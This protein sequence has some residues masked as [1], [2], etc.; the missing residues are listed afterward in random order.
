LAHVK[1]EKSRAFSGHALGKDGSSHAG[2][3]LED[4]KGRAVV[5]VRSL[6]R[7]RLI[8]SPVFQQAKENA[9]TADRTV[10]ALLTAF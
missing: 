7:P 10:A 6:A 5:Q 8:A 1:T 3:V 2:Y 4:S 9:A